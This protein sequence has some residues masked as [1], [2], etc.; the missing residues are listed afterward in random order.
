MVDIWLEALLIVC[1]ILLNGFFAASEI[2]IVASRKS[3]VRELSEQGSR[4]AKHIENLQSS[5]D[6]FFATVQIGMTLM[7]ALASALAGVAAVEYLKPLIAQINGI[8]LYA[9]PI[10]VS[11]VVLLV[12]FATLVIGELVPKSLGM[13]HSIKVALFVAPIISWFSRIL[14]IPIKLLAYVSNLILK[15]LKDKTSFME[16]RIS[17]EEFK[18]M[19]EEGT[20]T[21]VIDKTEHELISSIFEFTDTIAKEVMVPRPDVVAIDISTQPEDLIHIVIE[22]GYSRMPVYNGTLDNIVGVFYAKDLINLLEHR[23]LII[24]HDIVRPVLFV[25]LTKKISQLMREL[26]SKHFHMAIVVDEFGTFNGIV[27]MEDIL[28]EIVGEIHDEYDEEVKQVESFVDGAV[29]VDGRISVDDF[30][31]RFGT[32]IPED[33]NYESISGFLLNISGKIPELNEEIRYGPI[34]F[35]VTKK[36]HR[37]IWQLKVKGLIEAKASLEMKAKHGNDTR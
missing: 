14:S 17:E 9:E 5:P 10:S 8:G 15:P 29:F 18:L 1:L 24:L 27:T 28:E 13:R 11:L 7:G 21:G 32:L 12:T 16:S 35:I 26:Q 22:Q 30:N 33:A 25:P 4:R 6:S 37:R 3:K 23:A 31:K 34:T 19:L 36:S 2:S 20:K